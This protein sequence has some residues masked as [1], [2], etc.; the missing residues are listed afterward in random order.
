MEDLNQRESKYKIIYCTAEKIQ[1]AQ[2]QGFLQ[3]LYKKNKLSRFVIDELH[4]VE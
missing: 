3:I 2:F 4:I 1:N